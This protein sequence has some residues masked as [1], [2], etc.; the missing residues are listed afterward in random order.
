MGGLTGVSCVG[1]WS[2]WILV[3]SGHHLSVTAPSP[4]LSPFT[5]RLLSLFFQ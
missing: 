3:V 5:S 4:I 2:G 1:Q